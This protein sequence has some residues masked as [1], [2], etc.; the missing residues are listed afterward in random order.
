MEEHFGFDL[1]NEDAEKITTVMDAIQIF[2]SY[3][4]QRLAVQ[5]GES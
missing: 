2:H 3:A 5:E 4:K 1:S